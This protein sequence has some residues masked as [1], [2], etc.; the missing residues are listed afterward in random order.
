MTVQIPSCAYC[1]GPVEGNLQN[2]VRTGNEQSQLTPFG[3]WTY[4]SLVPGLMP[5]PVEP[6]VDYPVFPPDNPVEGAPV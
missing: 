1:G 3:A 2:L 4:Y 6:D 5:P